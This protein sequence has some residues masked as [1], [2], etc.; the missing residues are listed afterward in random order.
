M[1]RQ[2]VR[3]GSGAGFAGDRI[4]PAAELA[5]HGDLDYLVFECLA[6]RTIALA[7]RAKLKDPS[8][9]YN[10]LL[11]ARMQAVL[12]ACAERGTRIITNMGA[13]NPLSAARCVKTLARESGLDRCKVAAVVGDEV[14]HLIERDPYSVRDAA[15]SGDELRERLV[16]ANAYLGAEPI[17]KALEAGADVVVTGRTADPSLFLAPLMYEFGWLADDW[18]HLGRGTLIGHLLECAGQ[19]SGGY[20][21]DPGYKDVADLARLG[22]PFADVAP[23][24]AAVISKVAGSGGI[25]TAATCKEQLLY[26][27]HDPS[28]YLTPDVTADFSG[29]EFTE[30]GRDRVRVWGARGRPRP[31]PLKA[32]VAY[33]DGYIGEGQISYAGTGAVNRARLALDIVAERLALVG[34]RVHDVRYDLIGMNSLH[35]GKI[36]RTG[37]EPYEVRARVAGRALSEAEAAKLGNEVEALYTNGP[38]GG[39]GATQSVRPVLAIGSAMVP[40]DAVN[41]SIEPAGAAN[42]AC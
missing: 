14:S 15:C 30:L 39:G 37:I 13:A 1:S 41:W 12:P 26:E 34:A 38:A 27:I 19:I 6:E 20:F 31:G 2:N 11:A 8:L 23:D 21:A 29:V 33:R 24:G 32:S 4:E 36:S 9:G 16:S 28:A 5:Q 22:F 25:I 10:P 17:V 18:Q 7:Q 35:G 40:R 42:E 3:L